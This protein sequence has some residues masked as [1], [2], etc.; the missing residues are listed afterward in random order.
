MA[1]HFFIAAAMDRIGDN[2]DEMWDEQDGCFYDLLR[3]P[4]GTA[5]R[6]KAR[7]MVGL[8]PLCA[9]SVVPM[10]SAS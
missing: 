1:H 8:L 7:S 9:V 3:F 2:R 5:M 6:L 10:V 4:D